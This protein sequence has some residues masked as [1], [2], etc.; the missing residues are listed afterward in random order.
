[1]LRSHWG[2]VTVVRSP[3]PADRQRW[4]CSAAA[5]VLEELL[6]QELD[7]VTRIAGCRHRPAPLPV[8]RN[9]LRASPPNRYPESPRRYPPHLDRLFISLISTACTSRRTI[10]RFD[11]K[12]DVRPAGRPGASRVSRGSHRR[13]RRTVPP[14]SPVART[15]PSGENVRA[16]TWLMWPT[17]VQRSRPV[18]ASHSLM[19]LSSPPEA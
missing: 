14:K 9:G 19:V 6:G 2:T 8:D 13:Q 7:G 17:N 15:K 18:D 1:M 12:V 3:S 16:R 5:P 10:E 4:T 11:E